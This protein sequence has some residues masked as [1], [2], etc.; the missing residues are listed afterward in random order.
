[1]SLVFAIQ[2]LLTIVPLQTENSSLINGSESG[3]G[4]TGNVSV[5]DNP[6]KWFMNEFVQP[7]IEDLAAFSE[8][9]LSI[10]FSVPYVE[11]DGPLSFGRPVDTGF[12]G[13]F[14]NGLLPHIFGEAYDLVWIPEG[15]II[16]VIAIII[17]TAGITIRGLFDI[18]EYKGRQQGKNHS[19]IVGFF[20][21]V[22]W[23][24]LFLG[25]V[26]ATHAI[27]LSFGSDAGLGF[28]LVGSIQSTIIMAMAAGPFSVIIL[29]LGFGPW[30]ILGLIMLVRA[31]LIGALAIFGPIIIA[32]KHSNLPFISRVSGMV[33]G[34]S[35]AFVFM[36]LP[37]AP[38]MFVVGNFILG[39]IGSGMAAT[40]G[41]I[42]LCMLGTTLLFA[43]WATFRIVSP[44]LAGA[45]GTAGKVVTAGA[46]IGL[47]GGGSIASTAMRGGPSAAIA[48]WAGNRWGGNDGSRKGN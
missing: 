44:Q 21:I 6:A 1:M 30:I 9:I 24:P 46:T 14:D 38:I 12:S 43:V 5:W 33:L 42:F 45:A 34:K 22:I 35:L 25:A 48:R 15:G 4:G 27:M 16:S 40:S 13:I 37:I 39:A 31:V 26:N 7:F 18:V 28:G 41:V 36:P 10:I 11:T 19:Y 29:G 2:T 17:L 3:G 47:G 8:D 32:G 20:G 23:Y